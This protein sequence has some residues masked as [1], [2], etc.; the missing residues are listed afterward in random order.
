MSTFVL[1]RGYALQLPTGY[2]EIEKDELEYV[3]GGLIGLPDGVENFIWN[4]IGSVVGNILCSSRV[5]GWMVR[6][7]VASI[8]WIR[9]A[10]VAARFAIRANP[11]ATGA[12]VG[13]SL[14][15]IAWYVKSHYL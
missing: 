15:G 2:V 13:G 6:G 11:F 7:A 9:W 5:R 12:I 4:V 1:N 8:S 10:F 14:V 3:E